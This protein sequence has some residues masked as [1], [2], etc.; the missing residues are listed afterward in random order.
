[1]SEYSGLLIMMKSE[2]FRP[3]GEYGAEIWPSQAESDVVCAEVGCLR[4]RH[5]GLCPI[6]IDA[7]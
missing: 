3:Y 7:F 4:I 1:M 5:H 2:I 6:P